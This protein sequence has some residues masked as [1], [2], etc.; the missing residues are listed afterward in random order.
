VGAIEAAHE[1]PWATVWRV[2]VADGAVWLKACGAVQAF[3]PRLTASL[4]SR[5]PDRVAEVLDCDEERHWLLLRDAG[6]PVGALGNPPEAWLA[7]LAAYAELQRGEA[8]YALDHQAHGV[9]DLRVETLPARF[10]ELLRGDLPLAHEEIARLRGFS[11]R[12]DALCRELA[13][14][15]LPNT[16]Q[17][18]DLHHKNL[19]EW[20]ARLRV[21]D[22]GDSSI[23]Q[24]FASLVVTFRFLEKVTKLPADGL[25][26]ARLTDAYLEPWGSGL[27]EAF[28]LALRVGTF[29]HCFAWARQ[30]EHLPE[31]ARSRF[32]AA[33]RIVLRR[34]LECTV[35]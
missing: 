30:R 12:F 6:R 13:T 33:F 28:A 9:P 18:D 34:A 8:A 26:F 10:D 1:R 29:A 25:W 24:P 14:A 22:W 19:Y 23:S 16:I 21:L 5:W 20:D 32:D 35:G 2:P 4:F 27:A 31:E 17:H 3:E 7:A 15:G 11:S